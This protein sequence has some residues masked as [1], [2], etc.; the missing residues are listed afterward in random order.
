MGVEGDLAVDRVDAGAVGWGT[1][2]RVGKF[3]LMH[4]KG[5]HAG[6]KHFSLGVLW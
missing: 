6:E 1:E 4:W 3:R 5:E 2:P